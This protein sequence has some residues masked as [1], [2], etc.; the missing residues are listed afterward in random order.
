M[1]HTFES[2][3]SVARQY[4]T[5]SSLR[6]GNSPVY[7]AI[8]RRGW[9]EVMFAHMVPPKEKHFLVGSVEE[10]YILANYDMMSLI[11]LS[12]N[13]GYSLDV[14]HRE[15][16]RVLR[17]HGLE[18]RGSG[19]RTAKTT[20]EQM[21]RDDFILA[22]RNGGMSRRDIADRIGTTV[23]SIKQMLR[24][25]RGSANNPAQIQHDKG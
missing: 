13:L 19:K 2:C 24:R 17:R 7:Q 11:E 20:S 23:S 16:G 8:H 14:V 15:A 21:K 1:P 10:A 6:L 5:R 18:P 9:S 4:K 3:F 12:Y 25:I 22:M